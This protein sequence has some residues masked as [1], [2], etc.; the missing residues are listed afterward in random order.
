MKIL[1]FQ[2]EVNAPWDN[3]SAARDYEWRI[4]KNYIDS[5]VEFG[6]SPIRDKKSMDAYMA[7]LKSHGLD[8]TVYAIQ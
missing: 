7:C 6:A 5:H 1:G 4:K 8:F 3:Y 2:I